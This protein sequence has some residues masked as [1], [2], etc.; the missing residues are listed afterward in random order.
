MKKTV[1]IISC[2]L[3]LVGIAI[4]CTPAQPKNQSE[5]DSLKQWESFKLPP[6]HIKNDYPEEEG[7]KL[8]FSIVKEPQ[9]FIHAEIRKVL[10]KL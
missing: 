9:E 3:A 2:I 7:S 4:A 10:D 5:V 1:F 8:Y 6:V